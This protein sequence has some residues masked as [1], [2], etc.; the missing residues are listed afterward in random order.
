MK[1]ILLFCTTVLLFA[2]SSDDASN[3]NEEVTLFVNHYKTTSVLHGTQFI[4]QENDAIGSDTFEGTA[5]ITNLDFEPGFEYRLT[6]KK[7]IIQNSGT[8][9]ATVS[10][11]LV[12]VNEKTQASAQATFEIPVARFV[13]GLGYVSFVRGTSTNGF[14]LSQEIAINCQNLCSQLESLTPNQEAATGTFTHGPDGTY[15]LQELY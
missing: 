15:V 2:C 10:Y 3:I 1:K 5:L 14:V 12:S 4:I 6:V 13:N 11:E 7:T 9:A 8:D